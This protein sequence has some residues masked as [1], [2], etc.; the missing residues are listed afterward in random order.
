MIKIKKFLRDKIPRIVVSAFLKKGNKFLLVFDPRFGFWRV[1][2]GKPKFGERIEDALKREIKEE[3]NLEISVDKF[4][5]FGQ[6]TALFKNYKIV[7][8]IILYFKCRI[9]SGKMRKSGEISKFKWL[10]LN[11]IKRHKNLEPAMLDVFKR[12]KF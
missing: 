11:E 7:S 2:G 1:P 8:R 3:L 10:A 9:I 6:D 4:L 12:F 5:G